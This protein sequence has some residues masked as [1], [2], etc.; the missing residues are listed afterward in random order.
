MRFDLWGWSREATRG[1]HAEF[2]KLFET[3]DRLG[4]C[5]VWFNEFRFQEPPQPYPSILLLAAAIFARTERLRVG[6]AVL[7]LPLHEP[8][9]LAEDIAQLDFQSGG[10][11]DVGIGR[12][13]TP[14]T[15]Q[16][17]GVDPASTR[18]RFETAY[19]TLIGAWGRTS[20]PAEGVAAPSLQKP[21]PP[22]YVGGT[23]RETLTF[24]AERELP[25]LLTLE[26]PEPGQLALYREVL[27][28]TGR[29]SMLNRSSLARHVCIARTDQEAKASAADLIAALHERRL[30]AAAARGVDPAT[31]ARPDV[32]T[33][34]ERQFVWGSPDRCAET[35]ARLQEAL[36]VTAMRCVFNGNGALPNPQAMAAAERFAHEVAPRFP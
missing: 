8:R 2:L 6:C 10:R 7:V 23:S 30:A 26:P 32:E 35:V 22:I 25:I 17:M 3:A 21:H 16:R 18:A 14:D 33:V 5:G 11:I 29:R 28:Q 31:V 9:L 4:Y 34:L 20:Q 12:G 13:T 36:G 24:A 15:L 27:A 1:P 19:E